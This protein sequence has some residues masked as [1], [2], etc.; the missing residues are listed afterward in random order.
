MTVLA[1]DGKTLAADK[2]ATSSGMK[3]TVT[4]VF[5][6]GELLVGVSGDLAHGLEMVEWVRD[7]RKP[8]RFPEHQRGENWCATLVIEG[9][10]PMLYE[11]TPYAIINEDPVLAFGSGRDYA[12]A[13]MFCGMSAAEAVRVACHFDAGCGM[14]IDAIDAP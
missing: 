1:W 14:G 5:R 12:L 2:Q 4:K 13:A 7:G 3:R 9:G 11:D 8:E 6:V 10:R